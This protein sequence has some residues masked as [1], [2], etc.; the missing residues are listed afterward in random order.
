MRSCPLVHP[1]NIPLEWRCRWH[2]QRW[3]LLQT[4]EYPHSHWGLPYPRPVLE[5]SFDP[6]SAD[7]D[8]IWSS[9]KFWN[10]QQTTIAYFVFWSPQSLA[11]INYLLLYS[12]VL[13]NNQ[14]F[15]HI[16][17]H[18]YVFWGFGVLPNVFGPPTMVAAIIDFKD[19]G[20]GGACQEP[21][22]LNWRKCQ[23]NGTKKWFGGVLE[24]F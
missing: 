13:F 3:I 8:S 18:Y 12:C 23:L 17:W 6:I 11:K 1:P 2:W 10:I 24:W 4:L 14:S 22:E 5:I 20:G 16:Y 15:E 19:R 9:R 21:A 7:F